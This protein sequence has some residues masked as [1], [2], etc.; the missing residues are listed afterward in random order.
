MTPNRPTQPGFPDAAALLRFVSGQ[1]ALA[2]AEVIRSWIAAD[3]G[4]QSSIEELRA[5]WEST[6]AAVPAWDRDG[7]WARL[8]SELG[9]TAASTPDDVSSRHATRRFAAHSALA[10]RHWSSAVARAAAI[11]LIVGAGAALALQVRS[12][13]PAEMHEITTAHGQRTVIELADG[14]RVTLDAASSLRVPS[15][16]GVHASPLQFWR[17]AAP[18]R[19]EL[20]GRALFDVR[21]DDDRPFI[22]ETASATTQDVGTSFVVAAYPEARRTEVAVVEGSVALWDRPPNDSAAVT[23][24][25]VGR[26]RS[27]P[28][29]L[30][31][32]GDVGTLDTNGTATRRRNVALE[33]YVSWTRGVL[34]FDETPLRDVAA[35]LGRW[36]DLD[37]RIA[38]TG[39][40]D[41][42]LT[43]EIRKET[44]Q[45][46]LERIGLTLDLKVELRG[47]TALLSAPK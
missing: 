32:A 47:R 40:G 18:R 10:P 37:I 3:P 30:L 29:M 36:Y 2:E 23:S 13:G 41:R 8:R 42:R 16:L 46:A 15:D 45:E 17:A 31:I 33:S 27:P 34:V 25:D 28:L 44:A 12:A 11:L 21:H 5:A 19:L 20:S 1:S 43:A 4:R 7:V 6:P 9:G 24:T 35:Q 26:R 38:D 39:L 22:V 14:S